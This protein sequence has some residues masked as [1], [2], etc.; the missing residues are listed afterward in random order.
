MKVYTNFDLTN[1]NSYRIQASCKTAYFPECEEDIIWFCRKRVPFVLLGSGHNV[2]LSKPHYDNDFLIFNGNFNDVMVEN[3]IIEA[4]AGIM[5]SQLSE[6]A[7]S[8]GLSGLEIFYD[9]PSSLGGAVV[10]N[11]GASGHEIKDVLVKVK[12]IDLQ[13]LQL[14]EISKE[15]INFEYRNSYFQKNPDK[16]VIKS[17][18]KLEPN[19]KTLIK[20]KMERTKAQRWEKQPREFPNAGSVFKRPDG[21]FVGAMIDELDLKGFT[22]G[23]AQVSKKHGGFIVNINNAKGAD[24]LKIIEK[25]RA[26]VQ[27]KFGIDLE[28]EQRII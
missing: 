1:Y 6:I 10:M 24:I 20:Q 17:W 19:D 8:M 12:Y 28:V 5:M 18:L 21:F 23:G 13:D 27:K 22:V 14:K 4:E 3:K 25:V 9:I 16:L 11:A 2:I 7:L 26:E 15:S